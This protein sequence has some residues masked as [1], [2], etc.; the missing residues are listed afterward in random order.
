M[1]RIIRIGFIAIAVTIGFFF[2][3]TIIKVGGWTPFIEMI[4]DSWQNS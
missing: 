4:K 3:A 1:K 2:I